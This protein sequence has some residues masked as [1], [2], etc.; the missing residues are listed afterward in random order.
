V[1]NLKSQ[2]SDREN[3]IFIGDTSNGNNWGAYTTSRELRR[4]V[5]NK[6]NIKKT[7]FINEIKGFDYMQFI[8]PQ[9]EDILYII[10]E[11]KKVFSK[12]GNLPERI[13]EHVIKSNSHFW[14]ILPKTANQFDSRAELFVNSNISNKFF[15]DIDNI[16]HVIINGEGSIHN[17][18][19][20]NYKVKS[21]TLL[22]LAYVSKVK[23]GFKTHIVNHT[24][25]INSKQF[26]NIIRLVYPRL[27]SIIFRD[28]ISLERYCNKIDQGNITRSAD[29]AWL[30][31]EFLFSKELEEMRKKG[32]ISVWYPT[33]ESNLISFEDKYIC[34]N[35][36]SGF[37]QDREQVVEYFTQL[38]KE[39]GHEFPD[40]SLILIAAAG[41]DQEFMFSLAEK[42]DLP[43]ITIYNNPRIGASII[44]NSDLYIGGRWH[45]SIF[46][47]LRGTSIVNFSGN[48][49]KIE[50]LKKQL[51]LN[52]SIYNPK[53]ILDKK[54]EIICSIDSEINRDLIIDERVGDMKTLAKNNGEMMDR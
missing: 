37:D 35:G 27:D 40:Y 20:S 50:G 28:P 32:V 33:E 47:L 31:D 41:H 3:A 34:I 14:D 15:E 18:N 46:A 13:F 8:R 23:Y 39:M 12:Q 2:A 25:D 1:S 43:L 53:N 30:F 16:D 24:L 11:Y 26:E 7:F 19:V 10:D 4:I 36:G 17:S 29:A 44:G 6:Y 49:F 52:H 48:T 42:S 54:D 38:I 5:N 9:K 21:W 51:K 45:C 22:F